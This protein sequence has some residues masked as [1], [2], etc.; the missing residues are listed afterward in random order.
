[1]HVCV[2]GLADSRFRLFSVNSIS[3]P[4]H[5]VSGRKPPSECGWCTR[6]T[7]SGRSPRQRS[8]RPPRA[9]PWRSRTPTPPVTLML[10]MAA[11][12]GKRRSCGQRSR[13]PEREAK[14]VWF[15]LRAVSGVRGRPVLSY[16]CFLGTL[17]RQDEC[18]LALG[19]HLRRVVENAPAKKKTNRHMRSP[20]K[21]PVRLYQ[22]ADCW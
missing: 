8:T 13:L 16:F 4:S 6:A 12:G 11:R 5:S 3:I 20:V 9:S 10:T 19:V 1:M 22:Q 15:G 14:F 2:N 18:L 17:E 21:I 7:R